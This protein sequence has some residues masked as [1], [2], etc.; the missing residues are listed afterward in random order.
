MNR[1]LK[2]DQEVRDYLSQPKNKALLD[3]LVKKDFS[4]SEA[5][6]TIDQEVPPVDLEGIAGEIQ[7]LVE[8]YLHD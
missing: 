4:L 5:L 1:V 8:E 3:Q 6:Q 2:N 7:R